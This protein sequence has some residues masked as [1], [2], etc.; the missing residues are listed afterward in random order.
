[1]R[2]VFAV[3]VC[4]VVG[5]L[6]YYYDHTSISGSYSAE[7]RYDINTQMIDVVQA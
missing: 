3:G 5:Y 2:P 6:A 4:C 7:E 1:M